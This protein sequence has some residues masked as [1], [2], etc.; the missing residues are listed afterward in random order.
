MKNLSFKKDTGLLFKAVMPPNTSA[1]NVTR[2]LSRNLVA[3]LVAVPAFQSVADFVSAYS[4]KK[5]TI[6]DLT[7][8]FVDKV[9]EAK[10]AQDDII[11]HLAHMQSLLS[12]NGANHHLVIAARKQGHEIPWWTDYYESHRDRLWESLRTMERRIAKYRS[13]PTAAEAES[14]HRPNSAPDQS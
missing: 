13:D 9:G 1:G 2:Q 8:R 3:P 11:P 4:D 5:K 12:K 7:D 6:D 14:R 10:R